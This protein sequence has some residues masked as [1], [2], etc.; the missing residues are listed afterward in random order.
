MKTLLL[1]GLTSAVL[2]ASG[3][4]G[5]SSPIGTWLANDGT[6]I[7]ISSCGRNLCGVIA[8]TTPQNDPDT[9][10]L[11]TDKNNIDPAKRIRRLV[12]IQLLISMKTRSPGNWSGQLYNVDDGKTYSG[13]LIELDQS[14]VRVEGCSLGICGGENLTRLQ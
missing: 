6:K 13:N 12:G 5:V 1:V 4:T 2:I 10:R 7:R 9:H 11:W 14:S 8:Q 3:E